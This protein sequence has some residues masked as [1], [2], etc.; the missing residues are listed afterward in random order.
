M[1]RRFVVIPSLCV[2]AAP[3]F[4]QYTIPSFTTDAGGTRLPLQN[5]P[6][7]TITSVFGQPEAGQV[8]PLQTT[9]AVTMRAGFLAPPPVPCPGDTNFDRLIN[10]ADLSVLLSQF[11]QSVAPNTNADLNGDGLVNGA[12]LSVLLGRFGLGC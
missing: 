1:N 7:V 2:L 3:A 4:A 6:A 11:G 10:G 5:V 12:D 8:I 9:G